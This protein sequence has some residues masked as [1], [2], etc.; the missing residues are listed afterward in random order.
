MAS[1]ATQLGINDYPTDPG[2]GILEQQQ[3]SHLD[4]VKSDPLWQVNTHYGQS[5]FQQQSSHSSMFSLDDESNP[6]L[7]TYFDPC[8]IN[9]DPVQYLSSN[10][11]IGLVR[12]PLARP[13]ED[14]NRSWMQ[15]D[16]YATVES[17]IAPD[18]LTGVLYNNDVFSELLE[19]RDV[20]TTGIPW[21]T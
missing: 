1:I 21:N 12:E 8:D 3:Y 6:F 17:R 14:T 20:E 9:T 10:S 2:A 7:R 16:E 18:G 4:K 5:N 19:P 15:L 11:R 13:F